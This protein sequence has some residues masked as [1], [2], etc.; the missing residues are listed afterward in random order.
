MLQVSGGWDGVGGWFQKGMVT[1]R[2]FKGFFGEDL[3]DLGMYG[4]SRFPLCCLELWWFC[5]DFADVLD[6]NRTVLIPYIPG[7]GSLVG[8]NGTFLE[9]GC[10]FGWFKV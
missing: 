10:I 8:G 9:T 1:S 4:F 7:T 3:D 6:L 2:G 5:V